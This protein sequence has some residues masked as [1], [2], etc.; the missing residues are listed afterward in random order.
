[1]APSPP[2]QPPEFLRGN[3]DTCGALM[4]DANR[5]PQAHTPQQCVLNRWWVD[6][7]ER[8]QERRRR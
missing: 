6:E 1:M 3:C 2:D 4:W 5:D 7:H 8:Q